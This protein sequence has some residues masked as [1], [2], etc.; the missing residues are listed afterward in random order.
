MAFLRING[1]DPNG[2]RRIPP[3]AFLI[4]IFWV[5]QYGF[6]TGQRHFFGAGDLPAMLVPRAVVVSGGMLLSFG[7]NHVHRRQNGRAWPARLWT[8]VSCAAAGAL[9]HSLINYLVFQLWM[10]ITNSRDGLFF[11]FGAL[12]AWIW[13]YSA[14]SA[15]LL[16]MAY[17]DELRERERRLA[18]WQAQAH[19]AQMRALRYQLN[20]H[21][22]FNTLN[23]IASLISGGA[24]AAA[25]RVGAKLSHF[26]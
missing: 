19:S 3:H 6:V 14:I 23:S 1:T 7:I 24:A 13:V 5:C 12:V 16:A 17:S 21:F 15:L 2:S 26:P 20:P 9:L 10:P 8:A 25:E 11:Y 18:E 4:V 22:M